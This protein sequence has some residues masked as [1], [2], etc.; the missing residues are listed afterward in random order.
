M[1]VI[2]AFWWKAV[3]YDDIVAI[4]LLLFIWLMSRLLKRSIRYYEIWYHLYRRIKLER[5]H[6]TTEYM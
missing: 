2:E 3:T 1:P 6:Y 4:S 5:L